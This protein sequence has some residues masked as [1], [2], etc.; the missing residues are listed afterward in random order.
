M[1]HF[2]DNRNENQNENQFEDPALEDFYPSE[3][4]LQLKK[5]MRK[6]KSIIMR[7]IAICLSLAMFISAIQMWPQLFN[8]SSL[9][10]LQKSTELSKQG[11]I[12]AYKEAVV[13]IQDMH[14]KGTG[15]NISETG[16]IVTNYHVIDEMNPITV[17]FPDGEIFHATLL[18]FDD[19]LDAAILKVE[20]KDLPFLSLS[21]PDVWRTGD[22]VYVIGNPMLHNQIVNEGKI[23]EG[24]KS[25]GNLL[26]SA[27]IY[28][29]NSGSPVIS[30]NGNVVGVVYAKSTTES[31][32]YAIPIEKVLEL[33]K[34]ID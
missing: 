3:E 18:D 1:N 20:G 21:K 8:L 5:Q 34:F 15:F 24:S 6:R 30:S 2:N 28:K 25:D 31:I 29:G 27:P 11:D 33:E 16:L 32:G 22:P 10:F 7:I 9:S 19:L 13:T 23:L 4:E 14:S 26:I 12:Q 17:V